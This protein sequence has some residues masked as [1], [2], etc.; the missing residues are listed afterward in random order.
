MDAS[1]VVEVKASAANVGV[2]L[3]GVSA[4][5]A[6]ELGD[7]ASEAVAEKEAAAIKSLGRDVVSLQTK[8]LR[9][10]E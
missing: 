4:G 8:F 6:V 5:L 10:R 7:L 1:R 9:M 3:G 2:Q